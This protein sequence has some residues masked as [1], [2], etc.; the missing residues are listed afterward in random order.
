MD[1]IA[2]YR[3]I[4]A[5]INDNTSADERMREIMKEYRKEFLADGQ[6]FFAFKRLAKETFWES[7]NLGIPREDKVLVLPLP[8]AE[9]EYGDRVS[10]IWK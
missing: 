2:R 1:S 9:I 3:G 6:F 10:E 8:E 7:M 5:V 4:T